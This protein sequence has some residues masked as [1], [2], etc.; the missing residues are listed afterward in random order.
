MSIQ[1]NILS[2][3]RLQPDL[4][5]LAT[6]LPEQLRYEYQDPLLEKHLAS[7][8][9]QECFHAWTTDSWKLDLMGLN[10]LEE[11]ITTDN[12][13]C[14]DGP[15]AIGMRVGTASY[16]ISLPTPWGPPSSK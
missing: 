2:G 7:L 6:V 12:V 16:Q 9:R 3:H 13:L 4:R 1:V 8:V 10:T 11:V 5:K 15:W 14:F